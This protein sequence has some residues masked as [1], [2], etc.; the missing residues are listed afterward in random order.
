MYFLFFLTGYCGVVAATNSNSTAVNKTEVRD[1][2]VVI[3]K[4][5]SRPLPPPQSMSLETL[6]DQPRTQPDEKIPPSMG[7][8]FVAE[9]SKNVT[10]LAGRVASLNCRI[11]NLDNWTVCSI[12]WMDNGH[13][14][15]T[16]PYSATTTFS[17]WM[18]NVCGFG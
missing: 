16:G 14:H 10:S 12:L 6:S 3:S 4:V 15:S 5:E 9:A 7:P 17:R 11:K 8:Q 13:F 18:R 1:D 2:V